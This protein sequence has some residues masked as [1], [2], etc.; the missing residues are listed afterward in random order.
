V[1]ALDGQW[2]AAVRLAIMSGLSEHEIARGLGV[3]GSTVGRWVRDETGPIKG[4][5]P[6]F[7]EKLVGLIQ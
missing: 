1:L 2:S 3:T 4:L 7:A 6:W 5:I